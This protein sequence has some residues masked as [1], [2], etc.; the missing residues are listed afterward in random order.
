MVF[1]CGTGIGFS[2][3]GTGCSVSA[4]LHSRNFL[5]THYT[6]TDTTLGL[7]RHSNRVLQT[8]KLLHRS[9]LQ[10]QEHCATAREVGTLQRQPERRNI[11]S[12]GVKAL[13]WEARHFLPV[14]GSDLRYFIEKQ[15]F[16]SIMLQSWACLSPSAKT[17]QPDGKHSSSSSWVCEP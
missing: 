10:K 16:E 17:S 5:Q 12:W 2:Y 3:T 9:P 8:V 11:P 4:D 1:G 15:L 6:A 7:S 14:W 13:H